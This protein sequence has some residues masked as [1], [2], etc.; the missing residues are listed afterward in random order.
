MCIGLAE[1]G[2]VGVLITGG[3]DTRGRL[4]WERFIGAI[5]RVKQ[6]TGCYISIHS[7]L[8]ERDTALA[9]KG[10][11]VDQ[12]L[13]DVVGDEETYQRVCHVDFGISRI[14]SSLE[15]LAEVELPVVPHVIC[16]LNRGRM[17]GEKEALRMVSQVPIEQLVIVSLMALRGT[18]FEGI[19]T[20][21][22]EAVADI[23]AEARFL[24]PSVR[25]S[26]GCARKRGDDA[27]ELMA[28]DAGI[29]RMALPSDAAIDRAKALG[30]EIRYQRTCC[31]VDAD[32][33]RTCW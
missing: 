8:L 24:M 26:L 15:A 28:L 13:L 16:G 4:P 23:I 22:A 29:N 27:L 32:F 11:G 10:A 31:S 14:L 21:D 19:K 20:P 2:S 7:G 33:S 9:L 17:K 18:P 30:L 5:S 1:K 3:C 12:A 25:M 6:E